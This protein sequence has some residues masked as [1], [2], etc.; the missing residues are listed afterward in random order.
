M[1]RDFSLTLS[2]GNGVL[3]RTS[4]STTLSLQSRE[5]LRTLAMEMTEK[6][7]QSADQ[8]V[9][10]YFKLAFNYQSNELLA[11]VKLKEK[12]QT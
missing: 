10:L 1:L 5:F 4:L 11:R 8:R 7:L 2:Q 12:G 9:I 3:P 6:Y